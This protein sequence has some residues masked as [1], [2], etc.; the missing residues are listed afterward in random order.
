MEE[1]SSTVDEGK[2]SIVVKLVMDLCVT[3]LVN[4]RG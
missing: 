2:P 1:S 3:Y 4:I